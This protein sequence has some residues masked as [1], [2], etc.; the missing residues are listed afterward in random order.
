M[1]GGELARGADREQ[2]ERGDEQRQSP[3][4]TAACRSR[5]H[6]PEQHQTWEREIETT[7][8]ASDQAGVMPVRREPGA[9]P[10]R[11]R[12]LR[13]STSGS[14]SEELARLP[15]AVRMVAAPRTSATR[16]RMAM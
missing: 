13:P 8:T 16:S 5:E 2:D 7:S 10:C 11:S 4:A 15:S 14:V 12:T 9:Y 6:E 3:A 1:R